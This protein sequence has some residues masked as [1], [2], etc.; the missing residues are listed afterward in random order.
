MT[1]SANLI[2]ADQ[3]SIAITLDDDPEINYF[4]WR[5]SVED[6]ARKYGMPPGSGGP[7]PGKSRVLSKRRCDF[8][9]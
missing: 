4:G 2:A 1:S 3:Y 9:R 8:A 6:V 7:S 5:I